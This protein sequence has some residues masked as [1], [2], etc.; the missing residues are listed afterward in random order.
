[1]LT[2]GELYE[3]AF[4]SPEPQLQLSEL[5]HFVSGFVQLPVTELILVVFAELRATLRRQGQ[6]IPDID[7][8]IA[9]TALAHDLPLVTRNVR[10]FNRI[11]GLRTIQP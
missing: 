2:V 4:G 5:R 1:M 6:L 11:P 7:L 9:A 3:G 8:F 10:H